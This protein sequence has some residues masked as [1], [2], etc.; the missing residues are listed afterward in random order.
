MT[1][2]EETLWGIEQAKFAVREVFSESTADNII[3]SL[4][5]CQHEYKVYEHCRIKDE[6]NK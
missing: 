5:R 3:E 4:D 1:T 2:Y 6:F